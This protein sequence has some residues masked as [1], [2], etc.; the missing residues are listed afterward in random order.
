MGLKSGTADP[1]AIPPIRVFEVEGQQYILDNRRLYA[2][3]QAGINVP[4]QPATAAEIAAESFKF[5]T[6][7]GGS[8]IVVRGS[9]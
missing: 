7:N 4:T 2:F 9:R 3:Q 6:N 8:T 5:T 1:A